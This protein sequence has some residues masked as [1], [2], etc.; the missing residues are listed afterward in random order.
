[1]HRLVVAQLIFLSTTLFVAASASGQESP[2]S[3]A[4]SE[5][6]LEES[7]SFFNGSARYQY[8]IAL[9]PGTAGM[10]PSVALSYASHTKWSNVGY[11]WTL[12]GL[13][14][15]S[16]SAKC[17]VPTLDDRDAFVWRGQ[18]LVMDADGVYHTAKEGFARIEKLSTSWL[19]TVPSGVKYHYG[20]TDNAR[21]TTHESADVVHRWALNKVEDSNGNYYSIEYLHDVGSAAYYPQTITYTFND[22]APLGAYR[23]VHFAWEARPDMRTSYAEGTRVTTALRLA[24]VESR[25]D[26]ALHSRHELSY[27]L[28]AGGKSLLKAISVV[29][30]DNAKTLPPTK[31]DYSQ[32]K[33]RFGEVEPYGDGLDMYI[34]TGTNGASKMLIDIN[35]DGL[36]D[37]VARSSDTRTSVARPFEIRLGTIEGGFAEV[38]EWQPV[39]ASASPKTGARCKGSTSRNDTEM[40]TRSTNS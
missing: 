20:A 8:P 27:T 32:G 26:G 24:S 11:G 21:I 7:H 36:V 35:G 6:Q 17:G 10:A 14:E 3:E 9:P 28:G 29:G 39:A 12:S 25:V 15:I 16:R 40:P 18:E 38:I 19:V 22:A 33:P 23:T 13:D 1:M 30:R 37:E 34:S 5:P 31:F 2:T 4:P